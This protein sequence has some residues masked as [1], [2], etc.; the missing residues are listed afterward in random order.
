[1]ESPKISVIIPVY[2]TEEFIREALQSIVD[3]TL[4]DIEI[5]V[6]NDGSTDN[7][8][9]IIEQMAAQDPRIKIFS[10]RNQGQSAARNTALDKAVGEYLYFMDSDDLL[11]PDTLEKC[12][13]KCTEEKL[14][15]VFFDADVFGDTESCFNATFYHRTAGLSDQILSGTDML[16]YLMDNN[17]HRASVCINLFRRDLLERNGIRFYP[18]IVHEDELF[19]TLC[20]MLSERIGFIREAF[21]KRRVRGNSTMT[22]RFAMKNMKGYFTVAD[23]FIDFKAG[24]DTAARQTIDRFLTRMLN[25]AVSKAYAMPL[26]SRLSIAQRCMTRY[27]Q[28]VSSKTLAIL[29]LKKLK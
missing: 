3:Q 14:D 19:T 11:V 7:S 10:Q 8:L 5:I 29:L 16:N 27:R 1:M 24:K 20:Y 17:S 13:R 25:P 15:I 26:G 22:S 28:Y 21:F 6:V 12:Y 23:W 4:R 9:A 2:N 18:G